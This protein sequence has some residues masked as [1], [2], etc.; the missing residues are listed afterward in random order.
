ISRLLTGHEDG[1]YVKALMGWVVGWIPIFTDVKSIRQKH[2]IAGLADPTK[3]MIKCV[4][5]FAVIV[6]RAIQ[7]CKGDITWNDALKAILWRFGKFSL[8]L[9]LPVIATPYPNAILVYAGI[10]AV[11]NALHSVGEVMDFVEES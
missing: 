8:I 3:T 10:H 7:W 9:K 4:A 11:G 5:N 1:Q 2:T 6:I